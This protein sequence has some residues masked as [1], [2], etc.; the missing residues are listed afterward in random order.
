MTRSLMLS[1]SL[2]CLFTQAQAAPPAGALYVGALAGLTF[3]N[4]DIGTK[5]GFGFRLG[6]QFH[7]L[8]SVGGYAGYNGL[9]DVSVSQGGTAYSVN[10]NVW[11][12]ALEGN[13]EV[14]ELLAGAY[15]G[16]KA[17][18]GRTKSS[19]ETAD[20]AA[21]TVLR[22]LGVEDTTST[23]LA[24]GPALG[25]RVGIQPNIMVGAEASFIVVTTSEAT[26]LFNVLGT[27]TI[28]F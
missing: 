26:N 1:I 4:N 7:E 24:I 15:V 23:D 12:F 22:G 19:I 8:M 2:L 17:G 9:G 11:V 18:L 21:L 27:A 28:L 14:K 25:Y 10:S 3:I 16:A 5:A 6:S 13:Y 20:P